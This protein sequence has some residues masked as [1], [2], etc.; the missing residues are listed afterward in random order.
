MGNRIN[1]N[2]HG[3]ATV[4]MALVIM[5]LV[6]LVFGIIEYGWAFTRSGQVI[7]ATRNAVR[8]AVLP[9]VET[10]ADWPAIETKTRNDLLAQRFKA[11]SISITHTNVDVD[12]GQDVTVT[13]EVTPYESIT[14]L[15][16]LPLPSK[17]HAQVTMAKE[18]P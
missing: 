16:I 9:S 14:G 18:G 11:G 4:E 17:L 13:I 6:V 10:E 7:N 15:R 5:L 1:L 2:R 8:L 12:R 3:L